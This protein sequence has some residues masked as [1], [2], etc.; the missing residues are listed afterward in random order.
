LREVDRALAQLPQEHRQVILLVG[1]EG[2]SY[3]DAAAI[4]HIPVG[5][6]RSRLSRGRDA[7]RRLMGMG[8]TTVKP[9]PNSR[10]PKETA[11]TAG[12]LA[13]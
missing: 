6:V 10:L 11:I 3:E 1:L 5:T 13:A 2:M 7:L 9:G 4:L 8:E 12:V